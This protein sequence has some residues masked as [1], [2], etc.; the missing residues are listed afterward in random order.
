[1]EG[2][3]DLSYTICFLHSLDEAHFKVACR[4]Q[5]WKNS[6]FQN[7]EKFSYCFINIFTTLSRCVCLIFKKNPIILR[8]LKIVA[9]NFT[10]NILKFLTCSLNDVVRKQNF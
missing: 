6:I 5:I 1:M 3:T 2:K 10:M 9:L 4:V 7:R 8:L